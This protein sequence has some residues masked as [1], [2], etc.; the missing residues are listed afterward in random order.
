MGLRGFN[1]AVAMTAVLLGAFNTAAQPGYVGSAT[2]RPCH[3]GQSI[4]FYKNPHAR[5]MQSGEAPPEMAG[6][7][8]CHGP[9]AEHVAAKGDKTKIVAFS[10]LDAG[11]TIDNCLRCHSETI[12]RA[13]IRRSS[14][15]LAQVGC[16]SCHSIH[17][18]RATRLLADVQRD[19]CY[20][21]HGN[22]RAQFSMPSKHRVNEGAIQCSDCH[23]PHGAAAPTV[24]MGARPRMVDA[25]LANEE[26]CMKC[27]VDKRGPFAFEHAAVRVDG[28]GSCHVPH[29]SQ[30]ARLMK[31]PAT[32]TLCLECHSGIG[33]FGR[34]GDGIQRTSITHNLSDPRYRNCT[35]CHIRIHGSNGDRRFLR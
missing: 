7:E 13:Q 8:S 29:G 12:G 14:H 28:C 33:N 10:T 3:P 19:V 32:F 31:R 11:Q 6:C 15:T 1:R 20:E 34:Q 5:T 17:R 18:A 25:A 24:A 4:E 16:A 21:C 9:G 26:P 30:N 27:H 35:T 23:N 22:V 2:C